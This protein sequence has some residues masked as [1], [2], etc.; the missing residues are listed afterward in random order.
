MN[1]PASV[2]DMLETLAAPDAMADEFPISSFA[3]RRELGLEFRRLRNARRNGDE[4]RAKAF[5][6]HRKSLREQV[7]KDRMAAIARAVLTK[8]G[9]RDR[10]TM[11]WADHFTTVSKAG[12]FTGVVTTFVNE[13]IRPHVAGRFSDML[14][15]ATLHPVMLIYLDQPTS[16]G[17]NSDLGKRRNKGLNE[18]LAREV[19]ELHTLGVDG[20]YTQQ[21][22]RQ[23]AELLTGLS[24]GIN[25]DFRFRAKMAE[26]GAETVLG[27]RYGGMKPRLSDILEALEDLALHPDTA[28]HI[29]RK[30]AVHFVS[31]TPEQGLVEDLTHAYL[32][33]D[34]DLMACYAV[35]LDH[36]DSWDTFGAKARRPDEFVIATLRALDLSRADLMSISMKR[37]RQWIFGPMAVM[38]QPWESPTGPDGWP[39]ETE[40]WISPQGLAGRIQWAMA[41]PR[42]FTPDLVDP[43]DF[44]TSAL[45]EI[46]SDATRF[47][48][49][50]A[51]SRWEGVG[52]VLASPEFNRR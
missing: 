17:P 10:L 51:E 24:A 48:A 27:K 47:A 29:A 7:H 12:Y 26:P 16:F 19:I 2:P 39:E 28:A 18:N 32:K 42:V 22:I 8:D 44:V 14:K 30:L 35:L 3:H 45:G 50:A 36:F 52:L 1:A 23:F 13:A 5:K 21:D 25:H 49:E 4:E 11:F 6:A 41:A 40:A 33:S 46:A 9:F 43:R 31:D 34:G 15:A 20:R 37:G 38:G